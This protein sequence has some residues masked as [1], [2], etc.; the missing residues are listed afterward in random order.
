MDN[1][2]TFLNRIY[3]DPAHPGAYAGPMKLQQILKRNDI[4]TSYKNVKDWVQRQDAYSLLRPVRYKFKRQRIITTGI[5]DMWDAD[6]A[7]VSNLA[8]H[9]NNIKFWLVVIDVFTRYTWVIPVMSKH[10]TQMVQAF[11]ALFNMTERRP[12]HLRTDKGT[13]SKNKA[14]RKLLKDKQI[15]AYTTKN[16]TKSNYAERVIRTLKGLM[17]RYFIHKQTYNYTDVLQQLVDNYN[18][19]PHRSLLGLAPTQIN[20]KNEARVWKQMYVDTSSVK[21]KRK[22]FAYKI[23]I[24]YVYP[25]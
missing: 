20:K 18:T 16:E 14:V 4:Y 17:Y 10:H 23:G 19:R 11:E 7:D 1:W 24:K 3:F 9:N 5:D 13:E 25:I 21:I 8:Q 6:L 12:K 22:R 2:E 15:H